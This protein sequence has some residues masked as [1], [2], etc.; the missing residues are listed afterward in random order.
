MA[1]GGNWGADVSWKLTGFARRIDNLISDVYDNPLYPQ[2]VYVNVEGQVKVSGAEA[3]VH[4]RLS[5]DFS[6][7]ASYT[8]TGSRDEGSSPQRDRTPEDFAKA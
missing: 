3:A 1:V 4:A 6:L 8:H 5:Q 7:N 2:G